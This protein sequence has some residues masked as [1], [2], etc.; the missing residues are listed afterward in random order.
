MGMPATGGEALGDWQITAEVPPGPYEPDLPRTFP[1]TI[2]T[3]GNATLD[4]KSRSRLRV[5]VSARGRR[6]LMTVSPGSEAIMI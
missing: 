3:L 6:T 2:V 1:V 4:V 5:Q